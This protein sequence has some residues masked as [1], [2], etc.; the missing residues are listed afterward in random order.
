[1]ESISKLKE[2]PLTG[3]RHFHLKKLL[4]INK[5][6]THKK[7]DIHNEEITVM[8]LIYEHPAGLRLLNIQD[9]SPGKVTNSSNAVVQMTMHSY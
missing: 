4:V 8:F 6:K 1:M 9:P 2:G 5:I 7:E 3:E